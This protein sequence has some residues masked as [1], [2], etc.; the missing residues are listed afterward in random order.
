MKKVTIAIITIFM[1]Q[2]A[3]SQVLIKRDTIYPE[4]Q[5][6]E[7]AKS[8]SIKPQKPKVET[9]FQDQKSFGG[10]LGI[11]MGY[12]Q[13]DGEE[14]FTAGGRVMFVA[15][16]YIGIGFGGRGFMTMPRTDS[17][18]YTYRDGSSSDYS[19]G[20]T[21]YIANAGGYGG[22]YIEPVVLSLKPIHA[23]FP[24]LLGAGGIVNEIW[25]DG[26]DPSTHTSSAFFIVEPGIDVE[27][28]IATWFRIGIGA[29]YRLTSKIEGLAEASPYLLEGLNAGLTF[30][31]G[32]F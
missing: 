11:S 22:L 30:K 17:L 7:V 8:E 13:I 12:T 26:P 14:A 16:H 32:Y 19:Y 25:D 2:A 28:N 10:Y 1:C 4:Q 3:I 31:F 15:N 27:F 24:I 6:K 29:S 21:T 20:T 18:R 23:S 9:L 5:P